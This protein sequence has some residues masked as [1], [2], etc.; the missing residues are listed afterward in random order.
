MCFLEKNPKY[1]FNYTSYLDNLQ[2]WIDEWKEYLGLQIDSLKLGFCIK[3]IT[4]LAS[5]ILC[6][7]FLT[8]GLVCLFYISLALAQ[9]LA[10]WF[11]SYIVAYLL[12]A[13]IWVILGGVVFL[14]RK[15]LILNPLSRWIGNMFFK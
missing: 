4:L 3:L 10:S 1:M 15:S 2:K 9:G 13:A 8:V 12:V 5:L 6:F 11:G 14:F 7:F